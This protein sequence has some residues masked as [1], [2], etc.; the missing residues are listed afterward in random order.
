MCAAA[1]R[2]PELG[3]FSQLSEDSSP[4]FP[5]FSADYQPKSTQKLFQIRAKTCQHRIVTFKAQVKHVSG[6]FWSQFHSICCLCQAY[7]CSQRDFD[8]HLVTIPWIRSSGLK[9]IHSKSPSVDSQESKESFDTKHSRE[10]PKSQVFAGNFL[11]KFWCFS[12]E[13]VWDA[14]NGSLDVL[15]T[16]YR[17]CA[18]TRQ[19]E[20]TLPTSCFPNLPPGIGLNFFF[21]LGQTTGHVSF[22][23]NHGKYSLQPCLLCLWGVALKIQRISWENRCLNGDRCIIMMPPLLI[24]PS[25]WSSCDDWGFVWLLRSLAKGLADL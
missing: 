15:L 2:N 11:C 3:G 22:I 25:I 1:R 21:P 7:L 24:Y 12:L 19:R 20:T 8:S 13:Q 5:G 14:L 17:L 4:D 9:Q 18:W 23:L 6:M 16:T 10:T